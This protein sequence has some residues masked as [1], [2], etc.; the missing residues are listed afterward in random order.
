MN[1]E[2]IELLRKNRDSLKNID[3]DYDSNDYSINRSADEEF[4]SL[5]N[6]INLKDVKDKKELFSLINQL[7]ETTV[8]KTVKKV[9]SYNSL[10]D[11]T[12]AH[13][14]RVSELYLK[15]LIDKFMKSVGV[16][17]PLSQFYLTQINY[18]SHDLKTH[19]WGEEYVNNLFNSIGFKKLAHSVERMVDSTTWSL[20]WNEDYKS[21]RERIK[22]A[23]SKDPNEI[24]NVPDELREN[25]QFMMELLEVNPECYFGMSQAMRKDKDIARSIIYKDYRQFVEFADDGLKTEEFLSQCNLHPEDKKTVLEAIK[26]HNEI[27]QPNNSNQNTNQQSSNVVFDPEAY[28]CTSFMEGL[29]KCRTKEEIIQY[30][31]SIVDSFPH[32]ENTPDQ[33]GTSGNIFS[34]VAYTNNGEYNGFIDPSIKITN[35]T[36]GYSYHIYDRDYLYAFATGIRSQNFPSKTNLLPYVM[37]Y[38]DSYFG[39]PKDNI[40][41][42]D[43]VLYN[44][45]LLHAEEFY[46]KHNIPVYGDVG[47]VDQMQLSGDFPLSALKGAYAAQCV[48]RSALAQN[49]MKLCGYNSSIMYGDCESHGQVEGHCWNSI[50]DKDDNIQIIDYS[51]TVY[52]YQ[53]G[54][55]NRRVPY[56]YPI[57]SAEY[58]ARDGVL[59][60]PDYHISNGKRVTDNLNRKYAI[61][62]NINMQDTITKEN[63]QNL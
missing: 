31:D 15:D 4:Y 60:M 21:D 46:K 43:D 12:W 58:L 29:N 38:L 41:R 27:I 17:I 35:A 16:N 6:R 25:K 10:T 28:N 52:S 11:F 13:D 61:G 42:R 37:Q 3:G 23:I 39:F 40:D 19:P 2:T 54:K 26:E 49:I 45:A 32:D 14:L 30:V 50:R 47:A 51:N 1:E 36:L 8:D 24:N 22:Y 44:F 57:S 7:A 9:S 5:L 48:E 59:E 18:L 63:K 20:Y 56:N 53:D 62:K 33:I 34:E 55:F